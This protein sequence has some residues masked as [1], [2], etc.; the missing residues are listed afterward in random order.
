MFTYTTRTRITKKAWQYE[1]A[2]CPTDTR[3]MT[4]T[5]LLTPHSHVYTHTHT[6]THTHSMRS[7]STITCVV[8]KHNTVAYTRT[9]TFWWDCITRILQ[10][11]TRPIA[12]VFA[13]TLAPRL[14][15]LGLS[16]ELQPPLG[17]QRIHPE[18]VLRRV[19]NEHKRQQQQTK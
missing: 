12:D 15:L 14:P 11:K 13:R 6:H 1:R 10:R 17:E 19:A 8:R 2:S 9:T 18:F 5:H 3:Y 16:D 7:M 4:L